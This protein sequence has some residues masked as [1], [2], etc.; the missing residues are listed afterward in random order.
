ML[1][2]GLMSAYVVLRSQAIAWPPIDQPRL[3]VLAT[4]F[5]TAVL[6][7]SG[8][9][10]WHSVR[11]YQGGNL[12]LA[13]TLRRVTL[14]LGTFFL[15]LQGYEWT[16]LIHHGLTTSSSRFGALFYSII[17][18]HALHVVVAIVVLTRVHAL[19]SSS[20]ADSEAIARLRAMRLYWT[21]VVLVWPPLYFLVYLW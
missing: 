7:A 8:A 16:R 9:V 13:R 4:G 14:A 2:C 5:N 6:L 10:L 12:V 1:F 3:P 18:C 11:V 15:A 17:G 21:F 19:T 20:H